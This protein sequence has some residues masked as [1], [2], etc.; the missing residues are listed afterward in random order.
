MGSIEL[1]G[2]IQRKHESPKQFFNFGAKAGFET[3]DAV[4]LERV[5]S[6]EII[7]FIAVF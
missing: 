2:E 4:V 6:V 1:S 3:E 5:S 7:S